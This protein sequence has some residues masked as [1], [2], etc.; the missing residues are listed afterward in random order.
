MK[1]PRDH[2]GWRQYLSASTNEEMWSSLTRLL[3]EADQDLIDGILA[4]VA[5]EDDVVEVRSMNFL[6]QLSLMDHPLLTGQRLEE[7]LARCESL[8][9]TEGVSFRVH[10]LASMAV[11]MSKAPA[12]VRAKVRRSTREKH[13]FEPEASNGSSPGAS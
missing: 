10:G 8:T 12:E 5:S 3:H 2:V 13:G 7:W 11:S 9:S 1:D 4:A 6:L